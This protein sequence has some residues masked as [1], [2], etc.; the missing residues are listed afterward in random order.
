MAAT[1][2]T[3][4]GESIALGFR[5][6]FRIL[7]P[8]AFAFGLVRYF[9]PELQPGWLYTEASG[10]IGS[11]VILGIAAHALQPHSIGI[12]RLKGIPPYSTAWK[13]QIGRLNG[14]ILAVTR[15]S[16]EEDQR[17][18]Y[19]Y[20]LETKA[21]LSLRERIH[22]FTS[23]YYMLEEL[24]FLSVI[25]G[26]L[27]FSQGLPTA[28]VLVAGAA[29]LVFEYLGI[30]QL[31]GTCGEQVILVYDMETVMRELAEKLPEIVGPA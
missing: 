14:A 12:W 6:F 5:E 8:G 27:A 11:V 24:S 21:P 9:L 16:K 3:A 20:F 13:Q 4:M 2:S 31:A 23:F 26:V 28:V 29:A 17:D 22:Y 10:V 25:A 1:P 7:V 30:K 19:K 18:L 15:L